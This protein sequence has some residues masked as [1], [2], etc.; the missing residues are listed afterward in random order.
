MH[1]SNAVTVLCLCSAVC[2]LLAGT[3]SNHWGY[4]R[5]GPPQTFLPDAA[6]AFAQNPQR[7]RVQDTAPLSNWDKTVQAITRVAQVNGL[8]PDIETRSD[9]NCGPDSI[10][11]NLERLNLDA[12][13]CQEV[14]R[15]LRE[16]G[17]DAAI[18]HIRKMVV[19]W[20]RRHSCDEVLQGVSIQEWSMMESYYTSFNE[21]LAGMQT[22]A[23]WVDTPFLYAATAVFNL[24]IVMLVGRGEPQLLAS[25]Q[26]MSSSVSPVATLANVNNVHFM[27]LQPLQGPDELSAV[28]VAARAKEIGDH[29]LVNLVDVANTSASETYDELEC[30]ASLGVSEQIESK[31]QHPELLPLC[32]A[33]QVWVLSEKSNMLPTQCCPN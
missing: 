30:A 22:Q 27:A 21:Y 12:P 16:S 10:L 23:T 32:E 28:P 5:L 9:G 3:V 11:R 1:C 2:F 15:I 25:P 31:V 33:L 20:L 13:T 7:G 8:C 6:A 4:T 18:L 26:V 19:K 29:I 14:L 17:R 24:Q